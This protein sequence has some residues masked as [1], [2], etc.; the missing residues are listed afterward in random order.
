MMLWPLRA[1]RLTDDA[2]HLTASS[3]LGSA[4]NSDSCPG[5]VS[6]SSPT[7][8]LA[9]NLGAGPPWGSMTSNTSAGTNTLAPRASEIVRRHLSRENARGLEM[10]GHAIEYLADEYA[11]DPSSKGSLGNADPRIEAIQILKALNRAVYFSGRE[12]QPPLRRVL[13]WLLGERM[14]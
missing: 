13:R 3:H 2:T 11:F 5:S 7:S 6:D 9:S 12:V 1:R 4:P 10:L 8:T 14:A